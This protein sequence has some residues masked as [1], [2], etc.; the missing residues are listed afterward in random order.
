MRKMKN[1]FSALM[2]TKALEPELNTSPTP[3]HATYGG[4]GEEEGK[5]EGKEEG[6]E[7]RRGRERG[8]GR[9]R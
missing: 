4:E 3:T 9:V 1:C 7:G 2:T 8:E 5:E 6:G